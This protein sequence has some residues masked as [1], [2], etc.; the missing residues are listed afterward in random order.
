MIVDDVLSPK[1]SIFS[2][3]IGDVHD[4]LMR[5]KEFKGDGGKEV[6]INWELGV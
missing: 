6:R 4:M 5:E 3:W 1:T 2:Q